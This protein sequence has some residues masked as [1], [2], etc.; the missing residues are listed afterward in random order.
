MDQLQGSAGALG[1][2]WLSLLDLCYCISPATT[3]VMSNV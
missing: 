2:E 3:H 1:N